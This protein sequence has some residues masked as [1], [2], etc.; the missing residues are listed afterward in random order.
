MPPLWKRLIKQPEPYLAVLALLM[1]LAGVD[2]LRPPDRQ[3]TARM[4]PVAVR[5]YRFLGHPI[6][7]AL[8]VRCR[9]RPTCSEYSIEAVRKYGIIR[10]LELTAKRLESC[11]SR[12]P[13]GTV[14]PVP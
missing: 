4:Y 12:V 6:T 2:S 7:H 1:A 10:G 5:I 14:D 11:N 9:Y 13:Y 3:I 8:G